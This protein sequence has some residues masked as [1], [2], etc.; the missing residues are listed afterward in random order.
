[1]RFKYLKH[2]N[3]LIKNQNELGFVFF[4]D[5]NQDEKNKLENVYQAINKSLGEEVVKINATCCGMD[6][7][8]IHKERIKDI[9]YFYYIGIVKGIIVAIILPIIL[10]ILSTL[11]TNIIIKP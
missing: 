11:I 6:S 2:L 10:S 8:R 7:V 5:L 9:K 1:M 4:E 3:Y